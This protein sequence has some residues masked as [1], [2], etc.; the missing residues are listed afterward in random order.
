MKLCQNGTVGDPKLT[1]LHEITIPC[2]V[3]VCVGLLAIFDLQLDGAIQGISHH[4]NKDHDLIEQ[5][6]DFLSLHK[7]QQ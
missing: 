1:D 5:W 3:C 2:G 6:Q 4:Y 7:I